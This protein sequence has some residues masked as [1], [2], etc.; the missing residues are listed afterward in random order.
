MV[1][2][3]QRRLSVTPMLTSYHVNVVQA[4]A[5]SVDDLSRALQEAVQGARARETCQVVLK[6]L[7][8][9]DGGCLVVLLDHARATVNGSSADGGKLTKCFQRHGRNLHRDRPSFLS[10]LRAFRRRGAGDRWGAAEL[11]ELAACDLDSPELQALEGEPKDGALVLTMG[12]SL[13]AAAL[14]LRHG[15][16]ASY[17]VLPSGEGVGT[18]HAAALGTVQHLQRTADGVPGLALVAS[19]RGGLSLMLPKEP[20]RVLT[21]EPS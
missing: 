9:G 17:L 14:K 6:E 7:L 11:R 3:A 20:P 15:D 5:A 13:L 10:L 8:Q 18:R 4:E 19:D 21:A 16:E 1:R 12:G 2:A